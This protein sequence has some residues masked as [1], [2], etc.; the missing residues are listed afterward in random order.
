MENFNE[1]QPR[2][3]FSLE[4]PLEHQRQHLERPV[5]WLEWVSY[6]QMR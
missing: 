6:L 1:Q 2:N 3:P 4:V 5:P